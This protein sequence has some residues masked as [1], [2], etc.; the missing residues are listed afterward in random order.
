MRKSEIFDNFTKI[1]QDK[2]IISSDKSFKKLEETSR[3]DSLSIDNIN[4]LYQVQPETSKD[5]DYKKN[6]MEIAHPNSV[7]VSPAYDRLN[8]LV[9]SNIERQNILLNIVNKRN[10]GLLLQKKYAEKELILSLVKIANDL[11]N[12]NK[13]ELRSFADACLENIQFKKE[14]GAAA[15]VPWI[16]GGVVALLGAIYLHQHTSELPS[17]ESIE[18]IHN[19][20]IEKIDTLINSSK[21]LGV[22]FELKP[23]FKTMLEQFKNKLE[24][25]LKSYLI[26]APNI[27]SIDIPRTGKELI[28][29][30][31]SSKSD[32]II[33]SY[34]KLQETIA[35][36][37]PYIKKMQ[38]N[39]ENESYKNQ[40]IIGGS[41]GWISKL[42]DRPGVLHGGL[43]LF[44]DK[45]DDV[46]RMIPIYLDKIKEISNQVKKAEDLEN[47]AKKDLSSESKASNLLY[48]SPP[49]LTISNKSSPPS[50]P[51]PASTTSEMIM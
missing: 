15:A 46:T 7:I 35:D 17:S 12:K 42:I 25:F 23:E 36:I 5:M 22:G 33:S 24:D 1:A 39:F 49:E 45:F 4:K 14:A 44:S 20:L 11:D 28:E 6:I 13:D 48:Q 21:T 34:R 30:Y 38:S 51:Q 41:K 8:G 19:L 47:K 32:F 18:T 3:A 10:D 50:S 29:L 31:K 43:G 37:E 9:E 2:G 26:I 16:I 40:Q 27:Y